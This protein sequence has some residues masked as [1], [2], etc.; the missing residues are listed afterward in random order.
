M[1]APF[2][3]MTK[4][5]N[6]LNPYVNST[7]FAFHIFSVLLLDRDLHHIYVMLDEGSKSIHII[8]RTVNNMVA[9]VKYTKL[10]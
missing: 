9:V 2:A 10:D 8:E 3:G 7:E 4:M 5:I 6:D 1:S